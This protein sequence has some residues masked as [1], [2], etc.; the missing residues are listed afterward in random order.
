MSNTA[1][2]K[3]HITKFPFWVVA[4]IIF[5][6]VVVTFSMSFLINRGFLKAARTHEMELMQIMGAIGSQLMDTRL[7]ILKDNLKFTAMQ[8]GDALI[9]AD[10]VER[11]KIL[12]SILLEQDEL[13]YCYQTSEKQY[14]SGKHYETHISQEDIADAWA[15]ETVL[16]SPDFNEEGAYIM[17]IAVPVWQNSREDAVAGILI[18]Y[19][20]GYCVSRWMG[21]LF[22]ELDLGTAYII[23]AEGRNIATA[24]EENYDWITTRYNA[25]ELVKNSDDEQTRTVAELEKR[26]LDGKVG[27]DT[28]LWEGNLS[29]VA[30][31]PLKEVGWG[32]CVGFYGNQFEGYA[33]EISLISGRFSGILMAGF[34]LIV[35]AIIAAIMRSLRR[36]RAYNEQLVQQKEEIELQTALIATSEERFRIAMQRSRDIVLECQLET[37]EITSFFEDKEILVGHVGED[38]LREHLVEDFCM[39]DDGFGRFGEAMQSICEGLSNAEDMI[40]GSRGEKQVWYSISLIAVPNGSQRPTR[41]V[42]ILRDVTGELEAELDSMTKLY[43][44]ATMTKRAQSA[45]EK[46]LAENACAFVMIDVDRFK[47]IND[48]Y[49][50]PVGDRVL[51]EIAKLLQ[52]VFPEPYLCGRFGGDEFCVWCPQISDKS[53]LEERLNR[54]SERVSKIRIKGYEELRASLSIGAVLFRGSAKFEKIYTKADE[55]LYIAKKAGRNQYCI[56]EKE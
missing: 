16:I 54:L 2:E 50:H 53:E 46:N 36:E 26:A 19:M 32:F 4:I 24:K 20:D 7:K 5:V 33:R 48:E 18:K 39:D 17:A 27:I 22:A 25:Q 21:E 10:D 38:I 40:S 23:D 13:G 37:G 8:Y 14:Y 55:L 30:Y 28:Y 31:G 12:S 9:Q 1:A 29:Y 11:E 34:A 42:G 45:M 3:K 35:T 6:A 49:G 51:E 47:H 52:E 56:F 44:R 43:N 41:A 15:G